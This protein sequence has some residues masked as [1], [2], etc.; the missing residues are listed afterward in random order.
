MVSLMIHTL[1]RDG[2]DGDQEQQL[3]QSAKHQEYAQLHTPDCDTDHVPI[4]LKINF[5]PCKMKHSKTKSLSRINVSRK[6]CQLIA[7]KF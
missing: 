4:R 1:A 3:E 2:Y 6:A 5:A 7:P